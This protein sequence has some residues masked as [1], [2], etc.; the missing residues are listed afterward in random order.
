LIFYANGGFGPR[1]AFGKGVGWFRDYRRWPTDGEEL[2]RLRPELDVFLERYLP[3]FGR[4][5]NHQHASRLVQGLLAGQER[6]NVENMAEAVEGGVVR[7]PQK[8]VAEGCWEDAEVLGELGR[9]VAEVLGDAQG[10]INVDETGFSKKG[11]KSVGVQR[12]YAGILGRVDNCQVGVF[13]N[14]CS[15]RGHVLFDRRLFLPE[16]WT[17]E[18]IRQIVARALSKLRRA[19]DEEKI[20]FPG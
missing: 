18:P 6:R 3:L 4:V 1:P 2:R 15:P 8:F 20:D 5:E 12:Q 10:I 19:V 7:T 17:K 13:V 11:T 9:H 16:Q 14:Y